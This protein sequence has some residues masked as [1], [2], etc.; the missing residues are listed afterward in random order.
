[1]RRCRAWLDAAA[2]ERTRRVTA[3]RQAPLGRLGDHRPGPGAG[4]AHRPE[5]GRRPRLE[6]PDHH[7]D[8]PRAGR[9]ARRPPARRHD[10]L[11]PAAGGP[12]PPG[13]QHH[14]HRR[15]PRPRRAP[16]RRPDPVLHLPGT[17]PARAAARTDGRRRPGLAAHPQPGRAP[18]PPPRRAHRPDEPQPGPPAAAGMGRALHPPARG[19]RRRHHRRHR[20]ADRAACAGRP[21]PPCARCSATARRPARS[22]AT[23]PAASTTASVP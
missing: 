23:P 13:P 7:R 18:Q 14:P 17:G 6:R 9:R 21:S 8:Q 15:D 19:H 10:R 11:V 2:A 5:P 3:L 20:A 16:A 1:M 12:A 22:S 4:Q